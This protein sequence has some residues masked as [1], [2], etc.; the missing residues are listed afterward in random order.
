M[1]KVDKETRD[2]LIKIKYDEDFRSYDRVIKMLIEYY[3][4]N[5]EKK[6]RISWKK[7][8]NFNGNV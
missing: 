8:R 3:T 1:I 5:E 6:N 2:F 4:K 7:I